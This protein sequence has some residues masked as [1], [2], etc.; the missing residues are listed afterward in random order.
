MTRSAVHTLPFA[1]V[2][3][4]LCILSLQTA[5]A[6]KRLHTVPALSPNSPRFRMLH[7]S[8]LTKR[9]NGVH[10]S[11][12]HI[13]SF[14]AELKKD[15]LVWDELQ[16]DG[17]RI[18]ACSRDARTR[19]ATV[20][21]A[22]SDLDPSDFKV[23]AALVI[24]VDDWERNCQ[25]VQPVVGV[26][27][28]DDAL[29]YIIDDV[30]VT[31]SQVF[32]RMSIVSGRDV[33]PTVEIDVQ[34]APPVKR[35]VP[36]R[37]VMFEDERDAVRAVQRQVSLQDD[38]RNDSLPFVERPSVSFHRNIRLFD[39]ATLDVRASISADISNF[40]I[41]R[42]IKTELQWQQSLRSSAT[43]ELD[44]EKTLQASNE[45]E[46]FKTP[47]P[48]FG[49]SVKIPFVG[50]VRA[51]AFVQVD[52]VAEL[53]VDTKVK[54]RFNA[55]HQLRQVVDARIIPPRYSSRN[56]PVPSSSGG[57]SFSFGENNEVQVG[58]TGFIGLRPAVSVE[59]ALGKK[60]VEGN[61]G[62]KVG[63]EAATQ[64]KSP[65]FA[66]FT[67]QSALTLGNCDVCHIVRGSVSIKGKDLAAQLVKN[68]KVE[69][70]VVLKADL[71]EIRLGT[72][73]AISATCAPT[74]TAPAVP[75]PTPSPSRRPFPGL[76][77][78]LCVPGVAGSLSCG[79]GSVC[80][81]ILRRCM[82]IVSIGGSCTTG[83]T[84][85]LGGTCKNGRCQRR[86]SKPTPRPVPSR[87]PLPTR[88]PFPK[89]LPTRAPGRPPISRF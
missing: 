20:R 11:V 40:K 71:F 72:L 88:F 6:F 24:S 65:P 77:C 1:V 4:F 15:V 16:Q 83:C 70:E 45:G 86:L 52:W 73:C 58:M 76:P 79:A 14:A 43:A 17:L 41:K 59:A 78:K 57:S 13:V 31:D 54:V 48:K 55:A 53:E 38:G 30:A 10:A 44:I 74:T 75:T 3:V 61:I 63:V 56:L 37:G 26:D 27:E 82:K 87:R 7:G 81:G 68:N 28:A 18:T 32:C 23:G 67:S 64:A 2:V 49:F 5:H 36:Q 19:T 62:A 12:P 9:V 80:V 8:V 89:P 39:G 51:G 21:I 69:K 35:G 25:A 85:C 22:G 42:A 60:G 84:I 46:I 34:N 47:I 33:V 29:F 50:R 66:P